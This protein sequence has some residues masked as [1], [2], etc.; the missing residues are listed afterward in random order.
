M[1][2][3]LNFFWIFA[4]VLVVACN[5]QT[6][7]DLTKNASLTVRATAQSKTGSSTGRT[8]ST[9]SGDIAI[10]SA[11][12]IIADIRIEE[13]SGNDNEQEG[14]FDDG[15]DQQ[16]NND[17]GSDNGPGGDITLAGPYVVELAD[18][19][20]VISDVQVFPGVYKKVNFK[21]INDI[22][23]A[24]MISGSFK[25]SG[26]T[27]PFTLSSSFDQPVQLLLANGGIMV[28]ANSSQDINIVFDIDSWIS[29][30][31]L[32]KASIT[33]GE[34]VINE[35]NNQQILAAFEA[36]LLQHIDAED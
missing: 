27:T 14:D 10:T 22:Q 28:G 18:N 1:K 3:I 4:G 33:N 13:N 34:I 31:D 15:D 23:E 6:G 21:F 2:A 16:E 8:S 11:Q 25:N 35:T 5:S 17:E 30:L 19:L 26:T 7:A 20:A 29:S 32:S 36:V 9:S 24:I 12:V